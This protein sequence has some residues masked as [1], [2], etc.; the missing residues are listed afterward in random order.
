[1]PGPTRRYLMIGA[2]VT[3]VRTPPLLEQQ[4]AAM[5][6]VLKDTAQ[7]TIWTLP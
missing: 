7:G 2:P 3:T 1:M 5:G 6:I 4:L